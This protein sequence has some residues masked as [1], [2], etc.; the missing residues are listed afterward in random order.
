MLKPKS[1]KET[2]KDQLQSMK[3]ARYM[4]ALSEPDRL[5]IIQ[6]LSSGP[7]NV[8]TLAGLLGQAIAKV[9]HHLGV[10]RNVELVCKC[11]QGKFVVYHLNPEIF[12]PG[13]EVE[14]GMLELGCCRLEL[15]ARKEDAAFD[16]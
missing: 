6:C 13:V 1:W 2:M 5:K 15:G 10:L 9:S 14:V 16:G 11:K 7:K 8:G 12:A 3:C 4:K